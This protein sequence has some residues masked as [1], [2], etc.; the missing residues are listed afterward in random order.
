MT[1]KQFTS[2]KL[3]ASILLLLASPL[4]GSAQTTKFN[5]QGKLN[6]GGT[7]ATG[8]YSMKFS[9][10]DADAAGTQI[11]STITETSVA[12]T[13]GIFSVVLDFG[14]SPFAGGARFLEVEV[15]KASDSSYTTLS[16]RQ[17]IM[18][19]PYSLRTLSASSADSL[20]SA[21]AGCVT[22]S[23][24]A[25]VAGPKVTGTVA[26]ATSAASADT[27]SATLP[28]SKG[29]TGETTK[30]FVDLSNNQTVAGD[31]EFTGTTKFSGDVQFAGKINTFKSISGMA[32][33]VIFYGSG[34][35]FVGPV[36]E[37]TITGSQTLAVSATATLGSYY[38]LPNVQAAACYQ[39]Q[40][41]GPLYS[42]TGGTQT[43]SMVRM[44][45][46][47]LSL[48]ATNSTLPPGDYF[49]GFCVYN[50][51][52]DLNL[53]NTVSGWVMIFQN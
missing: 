14:S 44:Q 33:P 6:E 37:V 49:I 5:Y 53:N 8:T 16:P 19:S 45:Y 4:M 43:Y 15:K 28:I 17:Q 27:L 52:D 13:N 23:H 29:G 30:S 2:L 34:Y 3:I 41:G 12:V 26:L 47:S 7:V 21:C 31:K 32:Y 48:N 11:G 22:D 35:Q 38:P 20:S 46:N 24:I 39:S 50:L 18:S 51:Y 25:D 40:S 9:L 42:L 36:G 10:Y 1:I